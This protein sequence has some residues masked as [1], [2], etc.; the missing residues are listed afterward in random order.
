M[1][2]QK[3]REKLS[4]SDS[5]IEKFRIKSQRSCNDHI[6]YQISTNSGITEMTLKNS[7]TVLRKLMV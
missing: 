7:Y 2:L 1:E 3:I 5:I 6:Q 4:L